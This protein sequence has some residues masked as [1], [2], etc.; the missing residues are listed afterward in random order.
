MPT[1]PASTPASIKA[2]IDA[3]ADLN[4]KDD[5]GSTALHFATSKGHADCLKALIEAG[6]EWC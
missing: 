1:V 4:I 3:G 2:L 5:Y 6:A